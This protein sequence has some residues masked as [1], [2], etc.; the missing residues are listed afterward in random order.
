M[1]ETQKAEDVNHRLAQNIG[2]RVGDFRIQ[3]RDL[4]M[5]LEDVKNQMY[6]IKSERNQLMIE[7]HNLREEN[8]DLTPSLD[9]LAIKFIYAFF[10]FFKRFLTFLFWSICCGVLGS[11]VG[12]G[13]FKYDE[14]CI[15]RVD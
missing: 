3:V 6:S 8:K 10:S 5:Q 2:N 15:S 1:I 14:S 9:T 12:L 4:N 13:A 7:N 11:S